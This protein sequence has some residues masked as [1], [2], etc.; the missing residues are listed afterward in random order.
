AVSESGCERG[1]GSRLALLGPAKLLAAFDLH[2]PTAVNDDLE[3]AVADLAQRGAERV[4]D[5]Q[6]PRVLPRRPR[7]NG[8]LGRRRLV[9]Q[10][11]ARLLSWQRSHQNASSLRTSRTGLSASRRSLATRP[12]KETWPRRSASGMPSTSMPWCSAASSA[13]ISCSTSPRRRRDWA[14]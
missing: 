4:L 6:P 13:A 8:V 2:H 1:A 10:A 14:A 7:P 9:D 11:I 12:S 5:A 3:G